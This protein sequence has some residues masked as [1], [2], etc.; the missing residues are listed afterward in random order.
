MYP[1][2]RGPGAMPQQELGG[3]VLRS[4]VQGH[5]PGGGPGGKAL[6]KILRFSS[7]DVLWLETFLTTIDRQRLFFFFFILF[8]ALSL[9]RWSSLGEDEQYF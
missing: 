9:P 2:A 8:I 1:K 5:G 4:G 6:G 3:N 7:Y